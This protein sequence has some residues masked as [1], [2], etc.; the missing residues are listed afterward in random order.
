MAQPAELPARREATTIAVNSIRANADALNALA[1]RMDDA[2]AAA[3]DLVTARGGRVVLSGIGKSGLIARKIAAT[4]ASLGTPALFV[5]AAEAM[6]GDLG[7][8][9][10][11]EVVVLI[12]GS[13]E[14]R[15]VVQLLPF[16]RRGGNAVVAITCNTTSTLARHADVVLDGAVERESCALNL[17]P[18][19]STLVALA[20]GDALAIAVAEARGFRAADFAMF[21]PGGKL[22]ERLL[23]PVGQLM[24]K[25]DLPL[26]APDA[27][28]T[29]V[30]ATVSAGG[31][32]LA[33]VMHGDALA[34]IVTDG[35]LRRALAAGE[36]DACAADVMT[37]EPRTILPDV[38][39]FDAEARMR[40]AKITAL[41]V[42]DANAR[43]LG[44]VQIHD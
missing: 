40:E 6:H 22:G 43:V 37:R 21:H 42:T 19:T 11:G 31:I 25:A 23:T 18:T 14:T 7:Q 24:H 9:M 5:H 29:Q 27:T 26:V 2:I 10:P 38:P 30:A 8:I 20:L 34:G 36:L 32:G 12:S 16:L 44:V 3:V 15:E 35:D 41:V 39:M 28:L 1:E 13:G 17:A 4:M 33:L